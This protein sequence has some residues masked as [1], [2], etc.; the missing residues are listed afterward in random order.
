MEKEEEITKQETTPTKKEIFISNVRKKYPDIE[1]E[2]ELYGKVMDDYD[3]EHEWAKKQRRENE[4]LASAMSASPELAAFMTEVMERGA[5]GHPEMAFLN[6][7]DLLESYLKGEIGSDEY[8]AEKGKRQETKKKMDEKIAAQ[9]EVF[10]AWAEKRG[11]D[12]D[13][14]MARISE[15]LFTPMS[16][17]AL[18]EA[19]FDALDNLLN[20][21]TDI[22]NAMSAGETKGRNERIK[23]ER[24]RE[25]GVDGVPRGNST[26]K[27]M[28]EKDET[29][30]SSIVKSRQRR[31]E[32]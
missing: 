2:D 3:M 12:P 11:Y 4:R 32:L 30:L 22:E 15:K 18:A 16:E 21:D 23:A 28:P 26:P 17:Y 31:R 9:N 8:I 24:M 6:L 13:E 29:G 27:G 7:G 19:Q 5:D 25:R 10:K 14:W 1:D 20:Y